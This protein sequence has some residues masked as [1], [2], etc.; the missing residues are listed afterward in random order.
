[1][2]R[3]T[4]DLEPYRAFILEA[5]KN[6]SSIEHICSQ[7]KSCF[8]IQVTRRTLAR[9]IQ[10][11]N[12]VTPQVKTIPTSA[13][14]DRVQE[15]FFQHSLSDTEILRILHNENHTISQYGLVTMRKKAGMYHR[16]SREQLIVAQD[17]LRKFFEVENDMDHLVQSMGK[18]AL[19]VHLR[20]L[21][22][23]ISRT[24][25]W[26][27]YKEFHADSIAFRQHRLHR[28]RGGWTT[29]GPNYSWSIDGYCKLAKY[30]FSV[31]AGIDAYSRF[32]PWFYVGI[33]A[34][35]V[36]NVF[37]QYMHVVDSYQYIPLQL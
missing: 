5:V 22:Y 7:L 32:I 21:Q 15:L 19:Y 13:L 9:R 35:T 8:N 18:S 29:P 3:P 11:W 28:R 2:G 36:R 17:E 4:I 16:Q 34:S 31:Y 27:V 24:A 30:G 20:Q 25:M 1:M 23:V 12:V 37:A 6:S 10:Q 14:Q 26:E 33:S